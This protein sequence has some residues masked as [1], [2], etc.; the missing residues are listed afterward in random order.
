MENVTH[1]VG[2]ATSPLIVVS[3][4]AISNVIRINPTTD[5]MVA[6]GNKSR[7]RKVKDKHHVTVPA[8]IVRNLAISGQNVEAG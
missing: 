3:E 7:E 1:V 2:L 6:N 4:I 5:L 8:I